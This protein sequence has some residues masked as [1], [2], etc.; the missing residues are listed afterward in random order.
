MPPK[1]TRVTDE[2]PLEGEERPSATPEQEVTLTDVL[3]TLRVQNKEMRDLIQTLHQRIE[4]LEDERSNTPA[5]SNSPAP[6]DSPTPSVSSESPVTKRDPKIE[7]P[8][9]FTGKV[10][11]FRNFIAQ[12]TLTLTLCPITYPED[13]DRVLFVISRLRGT[14]LNWAHEIIFDKNHPLRNDYSAFQEALSNIYADRAYKMDC[15]DK[16]QHLKQTG[17]AASYSQTFQTLAAP[18]GLNKQSKCLMFFGGLENEVKKAIMI[19]G[20]AA[21]FQELVNQAIY[22][23]QMFYQQL[24]QKK[25]ESR[26]PQD[27]SSYPNKK[28]Q[29]YHTSDRTSDRAPVHATPSSTPLTGTT[30]FRAPDTTSHFRPPLTE[31]EKAHRRLHNLCRYC[32]DPAHAV[33]TCPQV[34]KKNNPNK[35][36]VSNVNYS[37]PHSPLL[38]PV[39]IRPSSAPIRTSSAPPRSENWQSQPPRM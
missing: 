14:P 4:I 28:H 26:E 13:Q 6:P 16:I 38:Y 22:F 5:R 33:E 3:E 35:P 12:C 23:D 17:S 29:T 24:R 18:L 25:R 2:T 20:R 15:E 8:D 10:S 36:S 27:D 11:E 19:A 32:G 37:K 31:K 21:E 34:E 9:V 39:P 30:R 7:P 1:R